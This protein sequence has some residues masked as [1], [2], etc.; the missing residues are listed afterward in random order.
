[1]VRIVKKLPSAVPDGDFANVIAGLHEEER[2]GR[3]KGGRGPR[4]TYEPWSSITMLPDGG[5]EVAVSDDIPPWELD[6]QSGR[7]S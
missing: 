1:M 5:T 4:P 2:R 7:K 6:L 3:G